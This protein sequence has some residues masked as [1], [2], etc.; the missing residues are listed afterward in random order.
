L[1]ANNSTHDID[2]LFETFRFKSSNSLETSDDSIHVFIDNSNILAGFRAYSAYYNRRRNVKRSQ[3]QGKR[4]KPKLN[5]D[6]LFRILEDGR[7][8]ARKVLVA[9]SPLYQ[10]LTQAEQAGY[11]ISVLKRIKQKEQCVDEILHLK[12]LESLLDYHVPSTLVL[13][14]GDG[15]GAKYFQGGFRKCV[16]MALERGWQVEVISWKRQL[17]QNF[18]NAEFL[19][20]WKNF[21]QVI[22]LDKFAAE[23]RCDI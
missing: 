5:Y 20:Q 8:T 9:S 18:T 11:E 15:K 13:A 17:S 12:I 1:V 4:S 6:A 16:I 7:N 2:S 23:L 21:Y 10:P 3:N 14:S 19:K 22:Y